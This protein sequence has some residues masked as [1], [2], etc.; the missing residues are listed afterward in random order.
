M[1]VGP[2]DGRYNLSGKDSFG[3]LM[4]TGGK[5]ITAHLATCCGP[6]N[7]LRNRK[8]AVPAGTPSMD[9]AK[10]QTYTH[11]QTIQTNSPV[12][13]K[14]SPTKHPKVLMTT[15]D[16]GAV[17]LA[18]HR[19]PETPNHPA[20]PPSSCPRVPPRGGSCPLNE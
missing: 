16:A 5:R 13:R 9:K 2:A 6:W 1:P 11:G 17:F 20:P 18:I 3:P 10:A 14:V 4:M 12:V 15:D 8:R 7:E 19:F